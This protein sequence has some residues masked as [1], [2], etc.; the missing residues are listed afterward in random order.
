[1][2]LVEPGCTAA[3][4]R[5]G[6]VC[7]TVGSGGVQPVGPQ[8]DPIQLSI[9]SHRFMSIAEQMGRI[10]QR[11]A[12]STNIKERLDFSCALFGPEG[13]LVSNAPHIPVHLGAMQETVQFQI[14]NLGSDLQEGD[15]ILS[16]HPCAGGSHLP[17]LTV[18]TPVF[19]PG[20][21]RPVFF[22]AS[23]GHHAD[24]GG[25]TPGSMP[26]H[27][28]SLQEEGAVFISFKLVKDGIFQE[29]EVTEALMAPGR[30]PGSSGTR[31]LH[32][33]LSDLRA[34]VAAN[35][36]GIHLVNELIGHYGLEVV[37][38]Y[39]AHIQAN[40]EVAVQ[41]M[42]RDFAQKRGE[43]GRPL[44]VEAEDFMDDGSPI[45]LKVAVDPQ[46]GKAVF[47]FTGSGHE[48]YGNCNAPRAITLSA[49]IYCLR[50]M[51]GQDIPLNQGCL[52]PVKTIIPKG[53]IL[54]P[55]VDA[56]VVGGN[57]LT[58]QRVVDVIFRA[59]GACAASQGC[60]NNVTFGN[61]C[62][63]YYETVAGGSGAGPGWHGRSGV[64]THMTNT[65]IT[66]PEILEKRYPV[67]LKCF[68]LARGTGGAGQF[69]GGDGVQRELQFRKEMVLS[70]LSE[71]RALRPYG[72]QGG[73]SGSPGLNLLIRRD[74]RTLNLG[75]KTSVTVL[76][77]V[78]L[79]Q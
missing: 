38:A 46:E 20:E 49:L 25:I 19:W 58:S 59:F 13:G 73:E 34:Q 6:D 71:R 3:V 27:S 55:S 2:I 50:C 30:I 21:P 76:P 32:D 77:G 8:V 67:I 4:T 47:D 28:Q 36:K 22:V 57:V 52:A 56:A 65:R 35:Q 26:P 40:A 14:R 10:L 31:N 63:S 74:G 66:D 68:E 54:D 51:V 64:H 61:E 75:G 11:T 12:I 33:N 78:R 69:R 24:I 5:L 72:L 42:L 79:Q 18:I 15:V 70:V 29:E 45:R 9:F 60:M 43:P 7:I 41:D 17:D 37:Q 39:M 62:V 1:T 44:T 23:R 53:S 48:V 16:N